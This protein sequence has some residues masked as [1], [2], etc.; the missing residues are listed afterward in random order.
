[1][2]LALVLAGHF[3]GDWVVATDKQ[4][5]TKMNG[6]RAGARALWGHVGTYSLAMALCTVWAFSVGSLWKWG[7]LLVVSGVT[8][9]FIDQRWPVIW[10]MKHTRRGNFA[11]TQWGVIATDQA[12]HLSIL[13][14]SVAVIIGH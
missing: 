8:H 11:E 7:V 6:G 2:L 9:A 5:T 13:C 4:A 14:I 12:L 3:L 1:M 10:L